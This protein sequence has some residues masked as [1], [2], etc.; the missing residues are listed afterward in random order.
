M[1]RLFLVLFFTTCL[2]NTA[3]AGEAAAEPKIV[4]LSQLLKSAG[5]AFKDNPQDFAVLTRNARL[6]ATAYALKT[7]HAE[8]PAAKG[9]GEPVFG[10]AGQYLP[11]AGVE[12]AKGPSDKPS[13]AHLEMAVDFYRRA[14]ALKPQDL[15]TELGLAWCLDKSGKSVE[16][17]NR[18]RKVIETSWKD[19]RGKTEA[20]GARGS[21]TQE[22]I[23][24][25]KPLLDPQKDAEELGR[26]AERL[27]VLQSQPA[28][29]HK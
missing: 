16:A 15:V 22:A 24:Y 6:H 7:D 23:G 18:Y 4:S 19:E 21:M 13:A 17:A 10:V 27:R 25:I 3:R 29:G 11:F 2:A 9:G 5:K 1:K 26:Y 8:L 14:L 12:P 28:P 20:S